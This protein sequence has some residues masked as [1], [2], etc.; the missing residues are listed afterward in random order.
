MSG[1]WTQLKNNRVSTLMIL[2]GFLI[3]MIGITISLSTINQESRIQQVMQEIRPDFRFARLLEIRSEQDLDTL[4]D[5]MKNL[6][7]DGVFLIPGHVSDGET[8]YLADAVWISG[9][10][11]LPYPLLKGR[12][13]TREDME[14]SAVVMLGSTPLTPSIGEDYRLGG[15][16]FHLIGITGVEDVDVP[17]LRVQR[18]FSLAHLPES[19]TQGILFQE[20]SL[21]LN[22]FAVGPHT[23]S[24]LDQLLSFSGLTSYPVPPARTGEWQPQLSST[25]SLTLITYLIVIFGTFNLSLFW[26]KKR[27]REIAIRKAYGFT[28]MDVLSQFT[29][30]VLQLL[31]LAVLLN[32][33]VQWIFSGYFY[34]VFG[35]TFRFTSLNIFVSLLFVAITALL[36]SLL[37]A[38]YIMSV[39][40][41]QTLQR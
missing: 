26:I 8:E 7:S 12:S 18:L 41:A 39:Q 37:P 3:A 11:S 33:P 27:T 14:G 9:Q 23:E 19:F 25:F 28:N 35:S 20:G 36:S 22:A 10:A 13:F 2:L 16:R 4:L 15:E 24:E 38:F 21:T 34:R 5:V 17:Y 31:L 40:P 29:A 6:P 1:L 32:F 30:E